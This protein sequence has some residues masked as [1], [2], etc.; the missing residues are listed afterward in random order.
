MVTLKLKIIDIER[1]I[2]V[3][4]IDGDNF[5]YDFLIGLDC[6]QQF[7]LVQ[8]EKLEITQKLDL[9]KNN[10][11]LK[12]EEVNSDPTN[13]AEE[14]QNLCNKNKKL[15][16]CDNTKTE[17]KNEYKINFNENIAVENFHISINHLNLQQQSEINELISNHKSLFA[18]DKYDVGTVK[19]Y[20]AHIDLITD[21]YC[22][23]RPYRCTIEDRKEIEQQ[24]ST[25]LQQK[26]IE[27]SYSP[28]AAPVTLAY[29]KEEGKRSRLR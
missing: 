22:S 29:K 7:N 16:F 10:Q 19:G 24:V 3:F 23:K 2:N 28:F 8:N 15:G 18:K 11:K 12:T 17:R 4:V 13:R 25:L 21:K 14:A 6:I 20:E 9:K 26:L 27:E 5:D 1:K